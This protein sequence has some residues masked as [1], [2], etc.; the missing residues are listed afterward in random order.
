MVNNTF[1]LMFKDAYGYLSVNPDQFGT[2]YAYRNETTGA[3]I[4]RGGEFAAGHGNSN[5]VISVTRNGSVVSISVNLG[6]DVGGTGATPGDEDLPA[7]VTQIDTNTQP[8]TSISIDSSFGNDSITIGSDIG[9]PINLTP[10]GGTD[11]LTVVGS[12]GNDAITVNPTTV[13]STGQTITI[14]G[15]VEAMTVDGS[16]GTDTITLADN[17]TGTSFTTVLNSAGNDVVNVNTDG[18]GTAT[19]VFNTSM[20]LGVLSI[21][22]GGLANMTANGSNLLSATGLVITG[23]GTLDMFDNDMMVTPGNVAAIQALINSARTNGTWTGTGITSTTARNNGAHNTTLGNM[24]G[25]DYL[26]SHGGTFD[27]A[28]V[29]ANAA[30]VKY[31][32]YGD[33]D[34]NG[35]VNFDDYVRT[36]SGFNNNRS[37][38]LNGDADGN[39]Q[40]NFDDYVLVDPRVQHP[41]RHPVR[42]RG[43]AGL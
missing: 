28:T 37:G 3:V 41:E 4:V 18:S 19:G 1:S 30:V 8:I 32:Y 34:F 39:G 20:N 29:A 22:S 10:G 21:G 23:T 7:F 43:T 15:G 31:T 25:A 9:V 36:D 42:S 2:A 6:S 11:S 5:D 12:A 33:T 17:A 38:W 27:G 26:G 24:S 14:N 35:A 16:G 13:V 40:V